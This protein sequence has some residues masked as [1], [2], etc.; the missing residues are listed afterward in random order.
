MH[1]GKQTYKRIRRFIITGAT[2][3]LI[4]LI[5]FNLLLHAGS[6]SPLS[7]KPLTAKAISAL[8]ATTYA[9]VSNRNWTFSDTRGDSRGTKGQAA[10]YGAFI[11]VNLAAAALSLACLG[12]S[13][14]ALGL[15]STL[16]DN[17]SAN[18]IG[19]TLGTLLRYWTYSTWIFAG[20]KPS[21]GDANQGSDTKQTRSG[22]Q[23][24]AS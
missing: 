7:D 6:V 16:A 1:P 17:I 9:F 5:T 13:R 14:Y 10:Q 23:F 24:P 12:I 19:I 20:T 11:L 15:N 21:P 2:A 3:Y 18:V 4:D 8:L 22:N